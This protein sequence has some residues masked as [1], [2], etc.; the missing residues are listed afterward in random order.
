MWPCE[1]CPTVSGVG[2]G[3]VD[4]EQNWQ[5]LSLPVRWGF[6]SSTEHRHIHDGVTPATIYN[7]V[8]VQIEDL[9]GVSADTM[10]E[11]CNTLIGGQGNYWNFVPGITNPLSP[12]NF[13][14]SYFDP[15]AGDYEYTGFFIK[16]IHSTSFTIQ[17]GDV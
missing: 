1:P 4:I 13:Q 8:I 6:W 14:L 9:Y 7:Y 12:H 15:G 11:V 17:W 3:Y 16:S 5:M 2:G 10:V